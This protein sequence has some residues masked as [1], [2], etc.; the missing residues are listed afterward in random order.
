MAPDHRARACPER[1]ALVQT[2]NGCSETPDGSWL[3]SSKEGRIWLFFLNEKL[4][5]FQLIHYFQNR[6]VNQI[7]VQAASPQLLN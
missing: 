4:S 6:Y 5:M 1:E 3:G 2:P 7:K